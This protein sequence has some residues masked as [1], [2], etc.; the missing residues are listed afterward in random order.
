VKRDCFIALAASWTYV[1]Y[2]LYEPFHQGR[3]ASHSSAQP[4]GNIHPI[5]RTEPRC[6]GSMSAMCFVSVGPFGN[7][8]LNPE[9]KPM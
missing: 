5:I 2:A 6:S 4:V 1:L 9:G 8:L 7:T 3:M